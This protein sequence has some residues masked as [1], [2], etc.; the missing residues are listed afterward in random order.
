MR[1][2]CTPRGAK[3][4]FERTCR[5][6]DFKR[7]ETPP[8]DE[9]DKANDI[10]IFMHS[11]EIVVVDGQPLPPSSSSDVPAVSAFM[12]ELSQLREDHSQA[13][14]QVAEMG[15]TIQTMG[16]ENSRMFDRTGE[17]LRTVLSLETKIE[18]VQAEVS[19]L[20]KSFEAAVTEMQGKH[21][22]IEEVMNAVQN[23]QF[24]KL[25]SSRLESSSNPSSSK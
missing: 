9:V 3:K 15:E 11:P 13:A 16:N 2:Q 12:L 20:K 25:E 8:R 7:V 19:M 18:A 24:T 4:T 5:N 17:T 6:P 1:R 23:Q 21:T 10:F 22:K 14:Q